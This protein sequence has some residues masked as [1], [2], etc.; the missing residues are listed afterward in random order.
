MAGGINMHRLVSCPVQFDLAAGKAAPAKLLGMVDNQRIRIW[1]I[2]TAF[3]N[4]CAD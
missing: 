2:E 1:E 3:N 4:G